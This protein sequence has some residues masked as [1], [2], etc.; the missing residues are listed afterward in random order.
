[1]LGQRDDIASSFVSPEMREMR[2][3]ARQ[4]GGVGGVG[5]EEQSDGDIS[6]SVSALYGGW[7]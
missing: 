4:L 7:Y 2:E 5:G 3:I 1:M 6:Y